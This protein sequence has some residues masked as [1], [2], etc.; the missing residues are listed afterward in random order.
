MGHEGTFVALD[1]QPFG[2]QPLAKEAMMRRWGIRSA[3][4]GLALCGCAAETTDTEEFAQTSTTGLAAD[5]TGEVEPEDVEEHSS[6]VKA[7]PNLLDIAS[8]VHE[9][10][11]VRPDA[12]LPAAATCRDPIAGTWVSREYSSS[13]GD[14]YRFELRVRREAGDRI[15]GEIVS[16][17][18]SGE[19]ADLL[20]PRC[21]HDARDRGDFDWTVHMT[22][23]GS[24]N[25]DQIAFA[26]D[27]LR[28]DATRCGEPMTVDRYNPDRF[29]GHLLEDGKHLAAFNNDGDRAQNEMHLFRR[30]A[31]R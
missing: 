11:G 15:E 2:H 4:L 5:T 1:C 9:H 26:G 23:S 27:G 13:F 10:I 31:C 20:P 3:V 30:V 25:G 12:L 19:P 17:S 8:F 16:R 21:R 6:D 28:V 18:W 24:L 29:T 7:M 22:G 14:W